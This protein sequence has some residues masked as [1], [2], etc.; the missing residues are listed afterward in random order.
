MLTPMLTTLLLTPRMIHIQFHTHIIYAHITH[1]IYAH[2]I[3]PA[4]LTTEW[5]C[6][7]YADADNV[8]PRA[9]GDVEIS[10]FDESYFE[11]SK[12]TLIPGGKVAMLLAVR[13]CSEVGRSCPQGAR[14]PLRIPGEYK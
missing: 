4:L 7:C 14:R 9:D 11:L 12:L 1:V 13:N 10:N 2:I 8:C 3:S 6:P 5:M